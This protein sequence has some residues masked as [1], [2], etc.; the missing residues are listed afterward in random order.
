MKNIL[1]LY[2]SPRPGGNSDLLMDEFLKGASEAGLEARR[3]YVRDLDMGGCIECAGCDETGECIL[4]DDMDDLYPLLIET[5][6]LVTTAPIFFYGLP[7]QGKAVIDRCQALWNRVRLNPELKRPQG[8]GFFLGVGATKGQNL[9]DG[10]LLGMKYFHEAVGLP[11]RCDS[12]TFRKVEAKGAI[13]DHPTALREA[14]EAGKAFAG[15]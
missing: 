1:A 3:I 7:S 15:D 9:F 4:R 2:M 5:E 12:L 6:R 11:T 13:K 8:K 14:F 10:T